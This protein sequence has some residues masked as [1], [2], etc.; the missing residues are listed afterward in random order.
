MTLSP[1]AHEISLTGAGAPDASR[2]SRPG[3]PMETEPQPHETAHWDAPA[4]QRSEST[5]F[6]RAGGPGLTPVYGTAQPPARISGAVRQ[7]AYRLPE[8]RASH[9]MTLLFADRIDQWEHRVAGMARG[10]AA[11]Y[12]ST[13]RNMRGHPL[14]T[15][16]LVM[17]GL[18]F[19]RRL[20]SR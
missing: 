2:V 3:V 8:T 10:D 17:G 11:A 20:R 5:V 16:L 14:R 7:F 1:I 6:T 4:P 19:L 9:W 12:R 15:S 18:V 13:L